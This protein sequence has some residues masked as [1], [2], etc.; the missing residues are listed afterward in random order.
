MKGMS[1]IVKTIARWVKVFILLFGVYITITGHL[2]PGGGFAGGVIIVFLY[3]LIVL[4]YGKDE[5]F[6]RSPKK[7]SQIFD[8]GGALVFLTVGILGFFFGG[9][10]FDNFI[11]KMF[12]GGEFEL[13]SAGTIPINNIA[14][15]FKVA[16]SLFSV[17]L[18]LSVLRIRETNGRKEY[19]QDMEEE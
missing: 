19:I 11:Q 10:F 12:P 9:I 14:I 15:C 18:I 2:T 16:G 1:L 7:L 13:L 3:I 6:K 5:A 8:S 17:F 4:A